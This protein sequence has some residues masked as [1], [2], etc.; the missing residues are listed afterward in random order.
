LH[1]ELFLEQFPYEPSWHSAVHLTAMRGGIVIFVLGVI[2]GAIG[3]SYFKQ[4]RAAEAR[5]LSAST[6]TTGTGETGVFEE[7]RDAT[8]SAS[9]AAARKLDEWDLS[10]NDIKDEL[11]D[12]GKVVRTKARSAGEKI[13]TTASKA[14][15]IGVIKT[16]FTLDKEL[17]ARAIDV[18]YDNGKVTLRGTVPNEASLGKAVG[19][20][21]DTDGVTEVQ[22]L[23]TVQGAATT[24]DR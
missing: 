15:V 19:L 11:K 13:A 18:D 6:S 16:K 2:A 1:R 8:I 20:A 23:L 14:R 4:H 22:S 24:S 17:S 10:A 9:D 3:L 12:T 21:L 7:M 5:G